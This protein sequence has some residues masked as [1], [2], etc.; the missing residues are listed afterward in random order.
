MLLRCFI[1]QPF[2]SLQRGVVPNGDEDG[3]EA[4]RSRRRFCEKTLEESRLRGGATPRPPPGFLV[5]GYNGSG[6]R[7]G[8]KFLAGTV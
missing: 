3:D 6:V 5:G 1:L 7:H 4:L 8:R 2:E